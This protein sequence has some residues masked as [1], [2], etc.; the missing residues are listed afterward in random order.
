MENL[1]ALNIKFVVHYCPFEARSF[2]RLLFS[3]T[4]RHIICVAICHFFWNDSRT[5]LQTDKKFEINVL[6]M[7]QR[8]WRNC[9]FPNRFKCGSFW[10]YKRPR[11]TVH[12]I[13]LQVYKCKLSFRLVS[14]IDKLWKCYVY[15]Q[16]SYNLKQVYK[17]VA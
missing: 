2:F 6:G 3:P 17:R 13:E 16:H 9:F 10:S 7:Y 15:S 12:I 5:L 8:I 14:F 1:R 11:S 4:V